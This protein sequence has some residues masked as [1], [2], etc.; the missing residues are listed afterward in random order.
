[1]WEH[2]QSLLWTYG[3]LREQEQCFAV[4]AV[5]RLIHPQLCELCIEA[6]ERHVIQAVNSSPER[7]GEEAL[8]AFLLV[9]SKLLAFYSSHSASS[10][11]P[12]D[13]LALIL[14]VQDRYPSEST[15]ED[16]DPQPSPRK[17][18]SSQSIPVQQAWGPAS[19]AR[20]RRSSAATVCGGERGPGLSP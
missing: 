10:L 17:P 3:R 15:V 7:A 6:L 1:V 18:W 2:F 12:A 4:E 13:L 19:T 9:H 8:H 20:A 16:D 14:L 5:E 11:R